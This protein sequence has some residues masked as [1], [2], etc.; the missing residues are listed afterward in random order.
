[1]PRLH[2]TFRATAP[3]MRRGAALLAVA[4]SL[5]L[6]A[7][8]N[9]LTVDN[10]AAIQEEQLTNSTYISLLTNGVLGEF[11]PMY[12]QVAMYSGVFGDE[13]RNNHVFFENRLIDLR[14]VAPDNGTYGAFVYNTMQ[15]TRF[16][17]DSVAGRLVVFL[18]DSAQRD[19]R[20]ART[21]AIAGYSYTIM[22]E[23]LCGAPINGGRLLPSADLLDTAMVRF[24][25]AIAIATTVRG[26]TARTTAVRATADTIFLL[27]KVGGSRAALGRNSTARARTYATGVPAGWDYRLNYSLNSPRENN[28]FFAWTSTPPSTIFSYEAKWQNQGDPRLPSAATPTT[29]QNTQN[30]ERTYVPSTPAS[31]GGFVSTLAGAPFGAAASIRLAS[32]LEAAYVLA[33]TD[34]PTAATNTFVNQRRATGLRPAVTLTGD[35]LM[36][37][38]REQRARD[39]FLD[40]RRLGD[41]RRYRQFNNVNLFESGSY[42][43]STT[44]EAY[45]TQTCLPLPLAELLGNPNL[46]G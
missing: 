24:D 42:P 3:S 22:G 44:G 11:Q 32:G 33:E 20:L 1:M 25:R 9:F 18:A 8:D 7:C 16:M 15:R 34:G 30:A 23:T 2:P 37:E 35:A 36:A 10:P 6:A 43:G 41:M 5:S 4:A 17:A 45:G 39:F 21:L 40:G 27:A 14:Q 13:L 31:F 28:P 26:D 12:P 38:L 19:L 46:G 29:L